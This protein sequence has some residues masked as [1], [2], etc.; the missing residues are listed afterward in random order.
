MTTTKIITREVDGRVFSIELPLV[1][2][3]PGEVGV[4]AKVA[5]A[6]E[7]AIAAAVAE[8]P[9]SAAG[10]LYIRRALGLTAVR[11]GELLDVRAETISRWEHGAGDVPRAAWLALGE[12][13]LERAGR[14][15]AALS[16]AESFAAG[17]VPPMQ[18]RVSL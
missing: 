13:A 2:R 18:V 16:R 9:S 6:G 5:L 17:N 11:L 10:V 14:P 3:R 12:L 15:A 7:A 8:A 1:E 4:D